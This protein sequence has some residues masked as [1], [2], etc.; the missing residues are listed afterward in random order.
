M[1]FIH[2]LGI[3]VQSL[4]SHYNETMCPVNYRRVIMPTPLIV[5]GF[6]PSARLKASK[7][8]VSSRIYT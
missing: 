8:P 5:M 4:V 3:E 6:P 7:V 1:M 2:L